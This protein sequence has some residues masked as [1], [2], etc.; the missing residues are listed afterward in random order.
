MGFRL[1]CGDPGRM[2]AGDALH[3]AIDVTLSEHTKQKKQVR[4][5][6]DLGNPSENLM[7]N[8]N[9]IGGRV[10]KLREASSLTQDQLAGACQRLG[11]DVSRVTVTKI[12]TGVR[13]VNDGEIVLLATALKCQPG[14]F[15]NPIKVAKAVAVVRQGLAER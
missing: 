10:R 9:L 6:T 14:D 11:W 13:A 12:E 8:Q 7:P 3:R 5:K 15:L 4:V 1:V 2:S